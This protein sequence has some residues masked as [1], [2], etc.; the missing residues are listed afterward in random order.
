MVIKK[1]TIPWESEEAWVQVVLSI[2]KTISALS[3]HGSEITSIRTLA[4]QIVQEY[5]ELETVL[6][7]V[8]L[9]SC[10][11]CE[12]V[13]CSRATVWYDLKDLLLIYLNTGTLPNRQIYKKPDHS[14][15]NLTSSGCPLIRSE[16][17]FICT[18]Y[19]CSDQ[20][21]VLDGL[22]ESKNKLAIFRTIDKIK[23]ARK[24]LE[25]EYV[26]AICG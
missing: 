5:T 16:R 10:S 7:Q 20:K 23:T 26:K 6:E 21:K 14:C 3:T 2:G 9:T 1:T 25:E 11:K 8:C 4:Q 12:D 18:W 24:E 17:P 13:C 22:P 19:I 15:C